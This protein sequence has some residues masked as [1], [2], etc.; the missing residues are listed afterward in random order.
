MFY[1]LKM[2]GTYKNCSKFHTTVK[3]CT[4][5]NPQL[6]FWGEDIWTAPHTCLH[7]STPEQSSSPGL[8]SG[9][10]GTVEPN[11]VV[12]VGAAE[13]Q[14]GTDGMKM[15]RQCCSSSSSVLDRRCRA[16]RRERCLHT[17]GINDRRLN[18]ASLFAALLC[19]LDICSELFTGWFCSS[20]RLKCF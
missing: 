12:N 8:G 13:C 19:R 7:P 10:C 2:I 14:R 20:P 11:H 16:Q 5:F 9:R 4:I 15:S 1:M 6:I 3:T 18:C 17:Y